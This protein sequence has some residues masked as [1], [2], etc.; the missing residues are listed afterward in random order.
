MRL[1][2]S[3][4]GSRILEVNGRSTGLAR[5]APVN[6][7]VRR[8]QEFLVLPRGNTQWVLNLR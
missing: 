4:K 3:L 6:L 1:G 2:I 5:R 7:L 8:G